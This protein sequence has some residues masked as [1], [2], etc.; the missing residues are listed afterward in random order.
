MRIGRAS[1]RDWFCLILDSLHKLRNVSRPFGHDDAELGQMA[2]QGID[3]LGPLPHQQIAGPEYDRCGLGLL[4]LG[5]HEAHGRALG[6]LADRLRI[7]RI[8][9]LPLDEGLT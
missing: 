2:A 3:D 4:A 6:R 5:R 8:V 7:G 1:L 9:L